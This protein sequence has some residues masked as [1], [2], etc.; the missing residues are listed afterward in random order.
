MVPRRDLLYATPT[1][2]TKMRNGLI[3][4]LCMKGHLGHSG[5]FA[6]CTTKRDAT[7]EM[8]PESQKETF[9]APY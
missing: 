6:T 4:I 9:N 7:D 5:H 2:D 3:D 1:N 8:L